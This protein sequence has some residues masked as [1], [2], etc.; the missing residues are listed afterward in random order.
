MEKRNLPLQLTFSH[1][2]CPFPPANSRNKCIQS[3][4]TMRGGTES[5]TPPRRN[6]IY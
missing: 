1:N 4:E 3:S 2:M 5:Q 6:S